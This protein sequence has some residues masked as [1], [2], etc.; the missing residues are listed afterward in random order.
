MNSPEQD[1]LLKEEGLEGP[2]S[3]FSPKLSDLLASS[4]ALCAHRKRFI[5]EPGAED[6]RVIIDFALLDMEATGLRFVFLP[7]TTFESSDY[8][9]ILR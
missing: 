3:R 7:Q 6:P 1:P 5:G 9:P 4:R 8:A 2:R